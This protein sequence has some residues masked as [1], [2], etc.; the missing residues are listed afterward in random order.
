MFNIMI[1]LKKY[2]I[3]DSNNQ[4]VIKNWDLNYLDIHEDNFDNSFEYPILID[5]KN[6]KKVEI[7]NII[8]S[9][10]FGCVDE[11]VASIQIIIFGKTNI[12]K[13]KYKI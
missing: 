2:Q 11:V 9:I 3:L 7:Y 6:L 12:N 8:H 4:D 5:S 13:T 1:F 10:G